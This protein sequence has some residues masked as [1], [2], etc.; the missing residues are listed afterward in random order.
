MLVLVRRVELW[1]LAS[2]EPRGNP[3]GKPDLS[4]ELGCFRS[5]WPSSPRLCSQRL[6]YLASCADELRCL[7]RVKVEDGNDMLMAEQTL[8]ELHLFNSRLRQFAAE[9]GEPEFDTYQRLMM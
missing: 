9:A 8:K 5:R 6:P 1:P 7:L 3:T 4:Q 2:S